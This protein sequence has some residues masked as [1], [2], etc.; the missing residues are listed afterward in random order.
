MATRDIS[1]DG[2]D[3]ETTGEL[4][5]T[6]CPECPG[7][8]VT[9]GG[10]TRCE[11]CGLVIEA[12]RL[13]RRGPRVFDETDS[14]RKRTGSPLTNARHDR[15]LSTCIGQRQD[16]KG[17]DLSSQKRRQLARLR[18]EHTRAKWRSKAER[19][20]GHGCTEIA[21]MVS[22]LGFD[23]GLREQAATLF[24]TAQDADLLRGRSI[25]AI[26]AG[27]VY[28]ACRC[29]EHPC[30]VA[31]V[32]TVAR[33]AEDRIRNAY[34]V[35]NRELDLPVPPQEPV[36]FIPKLA[37]AVDAAPAVERTA[38]ELATQ[39]VETGLASG[40]NPAGFAAACI[41]VAA[42]EHGTEVLQFELAAAA[43]VCPVTVRTQ[44]DALL[45][46]EWV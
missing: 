20:L 38:R 37:S 4:S 26:A 11:S 1:T 17:N 25:E 7:T 39:A 41:E 10:E 2:F 46:E 40:R 33:V 18:R 16:G 23:R 31:E 15:G 36:E 3:E 8:L 42:A 24:R 5:T 19:N 29:S 22:A 32:T 28:A 27:C 6:D 13:D 12:A 45:A 43:D 30:T 14:N 9:D 21:R 34:L 35:L 44:R